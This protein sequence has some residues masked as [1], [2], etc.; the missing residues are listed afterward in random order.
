MVLFSKTAILWKK[1]SFG[2]HVHIPSTP[3]TL[4]DTPYVSSN[5]RLLKIVRL[6]KI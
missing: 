4:R 6:D 5:I 3:K 1:V 2:P